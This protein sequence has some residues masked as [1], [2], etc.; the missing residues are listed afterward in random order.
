MNII[1]NSSE[2]TLNIYPNPVSK[3]LQIG[4][5][6]IENNDVKIFNMLGQEFSDSI[7]IYS[8]N[9]IDLSKLPKGLY[10]LKIK[11]FVN[12]VYKQ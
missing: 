7:I 4:G 6:V 11:H 2:K 10:I 3:I 12:K 8:G 9:K 5:V 1:D